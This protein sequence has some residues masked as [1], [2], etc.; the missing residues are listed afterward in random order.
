[1]IA[2]VGV[3]LL[4]GV[5]SFALWTLALPLVV[6]IALSTGMRG[7]LSAGAVVTVV[8]CAM[9]VMGP[10]HSEHPSA[11][12]L[13]TGLLILASWL[14][15]V[16]VALTQAQQWAAFDAE[17]RELDGHR[18][19]LRSCP[20]AL[21]VVDLEGR[22]TVWN[23]AAERL[24]GWTQQETLGR[25]PV[26]VPSA[27]YEEFSEICAT[28]QRGELVS[29]FLTARR[30]RDGSMLPVRM[31][32]APLRTGAGKV[33]GTISAFEDFSQ[34]NQVNAERNRFF[35]VLE[36]SPAF[37]AIADTSGRVTYINPAGR[38]LIGLEEKE[39]CAHFSISDFVPESM[40]GKTFEEV[41]PTLETEGK[42]S[43]ETSFRH[44]DGHSI[45][46][47]QVALGHR[48]GAGRIEFY[49]TVA[50]DLSNRIDVER[51][52]RD[53]E[54]KL[55][56]A[57]RMEVV[58]MLAGGIA[59]D[60]NNLITVMLG[61]SDLALAKLP[62]EHAARKEILDVQ[63]VSERASVLASQ[64][65]AFGRK[66]RLSGDLVSLNSVV[67]GIEGILK[68]VLGERTRLQFA[69][70]DAVG[71]VRVD[72]GQ[73]EQVV[74]N[75]VVNAR[76]AMPGGGTLTIET[77]NEELRLEAGSELENADAFVDDQARDNEDDLGAYVRLTVHD[78]GAGMGVQTQSRLFEP[79]FTTKELGKGTG[80]GLSTVHG[81][82][83]Q[84]GGFVSVHSTKGDGAT[85][86]VYLPRADPEFF[87]AP[88]PSDERPPDVHGAESILVVEEEQV[89]RELIER[90][91]TERGYHVLAV[92]DAES[93]SNLGRDS[94]STI[95]LVLTDLMLPGRSG[96]LLARDIRRIVPAMPFVVMSGHLENA[97]RAAET[98]LVQHWRL[99][100][101]FSAED[102]ARRVRQA[103]DGH[104]SA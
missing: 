8:A 6:W 79:F 56:Q 53:A 22:V 63:R 94:L 16:L 59:H 61:A 33:L 71:S 15:A 54:E 89:V 27:K 87:V 84:A 55:R 83:E 75:L 91:L 90:V 86:H 19:L 101:P 46:M 50:H 3:V 35:A 57:Q 78:T 4:G 12:P 41:I 100:K 39:L 26:V 64:L 68:R 60:F 99:T 97:N 102:L 92:P 1:M 81:I 11:T 40:L 25:S 20:S 65:L 104:A 82:V 7:A 72:A 23:P 67:L 96:L 76:D 28:T 32:A 18:S 14:C 58:G 30:T 34:F 85:F 74:M 29:G 88:V 103:L 95:Q 66:K 77:S 36:A 13:H 44:R 37:V 5:G 47:F 80:L 21:S 98:E 51:Q 24:F 43:G 62:A 45:P 42:W 49:S 73:L 38:T 9:L 2:L 31:L 70:G 93:V 52:L 69:L 48:D 10:G 17:K